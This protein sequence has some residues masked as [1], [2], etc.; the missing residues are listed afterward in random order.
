MISF[1]CPQCGKEFSVADELAGRKARCKKCGAIVTI[2]AAPAAAPTH[3]SNRARTQPKSPPAAAA[4]GAAQPRSPQR[5]P[6]QRAAQPAQRAAR[7][8]A[9]I[10]PAAEPHDLLGGPNIDLGALGPLDAPA[11]PGMSSAP[12]SGGAALGH[13]Y[14]KKKKGGGL[15]VWLVVSG[16]GLAVAGIVAILAVVLINLP[17]AASFPDDPAAYLP[18]DSAVS[19][20]IKVRNLIDR[21]SAIPQAKPQIDQALS[22]AISEGFDPRDLEELFVVT[23][24]TNSSIAARLARPVDPL[25]MKGTAAT[26]ESHQ[27]LPIYSAK[28]K[29]QPRNAMAVSAP[30][31]LYLVLPRPQL[32]VASNDQQRLKAA[33][34]RAKEGRGGSVDLPRGH[35]LALRIKDFSQLQSG[36]ALPTNTADTGLVGLMGT[37]DFNDK[38]SLDV[39]LDMKDALKAAKLDQTIKESMRFLAMSKQGQLNA[40]DLANAIKVSVTGTQLRLNASMLTSQLASLAASS[41]APEMPPGGGAAVGMPTGSPMPT[42]MPP[43]AAQPMPPPGTP[44]TR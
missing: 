4:R 33:I 24:G 23:D 32:F 14:T 2:A 9:A 39:Q 38:L 10:P 29:P 18:A 20:S 21:A 27:G 12:L 3:A 44:P 6:A 36:A 19:A 35:D 1:A 5:A 30:E 8:P 31:T 28:S 40:P 26:G 17:K 34:D 41:D 15:L 11:L 13:K 25:S 7:P 43:G 42:G 22:S 16:T 37:L